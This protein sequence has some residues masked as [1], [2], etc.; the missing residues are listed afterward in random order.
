M[1]PPICTRL[2]SILNET[3]SG[4]KTYFAIFPH[5]HNYGERYEMSVIRNGKE[6]N[7]LL[8]IGWDFN[9]QFN[10]Q[11]PHTSILPGDQLLHKFS[12]R[13]SYNETILGG[14]LTCDNTNCNFSFGLFIM[15]DMKNILF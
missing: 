4:E 7:K 5:M 1:T 15:C 11:I 13:S 9:F 12:F 8:S 3:N 6:V 2:A 14:E 10:Y